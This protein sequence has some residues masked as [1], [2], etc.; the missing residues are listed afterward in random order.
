METPRPET[1]PSETRPQGCAV[2]IVSYHT[3]PCLMDCIR[4]ALGEASAQE[5]VVV[6]NGNPPKVVT[7]LEEMAASEPRLA[8]LT[9]HGNVGFGK[10][11]NLGAA[12]TA[13]PHLLLLNP[14][15]VLQ[16]GSLDG[17]MTLLG[18]R[19]DIALYTV[20]IENPDGSEQ[21]GCRRNL[22]TPWTCLVEAFGLHKLGFK[23]INLN[24]T[25]PPAAMTEVECISGSF[26]LFPRS[27]F[28]R[29]GGM[30]EDYFLHMEDVDV[31]L[32]TRKAGG[33]IWFDPAFSATHVQGTSETTKLY[34]ERQ[35]TKGGTL[36][37]AKH[38]G[39][40]ANPLVALVN[41]ALWARYALIALRL[42]LKR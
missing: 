24:H 39:G 2:I 16:P 20:R 8:L 21:R 37:F 15:N 3:G 33:G 25:P 26:M 34:I 13:S 27:F 28:E 17:A 12:A 31:C 14:D 9:G 6:D 22:M 23:R 1:P 11:C 19:P 4:A 38:F 7:A 18:T 35:K 29:I 41:T 5:V 42:G 32:R 36:Y 30:D 10:A 40:W